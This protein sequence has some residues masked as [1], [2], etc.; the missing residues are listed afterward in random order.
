MSLVRPWPLAW[1]L[2]QLAAEV[3]EMKV[4]DP[5]VDCPFPR[6]GRAREYG[7]ERS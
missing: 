7:R 5:A 3:E 4:V 2:P 6:P 1:H